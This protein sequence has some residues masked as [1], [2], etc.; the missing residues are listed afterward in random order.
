MCLHKKKEIITESMQAPLHTHA[1]TMLPNCPRITAMIKIAFNLTV[2]VV[3]DDVFTELKSLLE[4]NMHEELI[5][6][7]D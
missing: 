5:D 2:V 7:E 1:L 6:M 3:V 4:H